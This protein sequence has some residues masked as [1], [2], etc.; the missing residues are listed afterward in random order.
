MILAMLICCAVQGRAEYASFTPLGFLP[1]GSNSQ[2]NAVSADGLVV[3]GEAHLP[4]GQSLQTRAFRWS[5]AEGM[6]ALGTLPGGGANWATAASLDGSVVVGAGVDSSLKSQAFRWTSA[7]GMVGLGFLSG[8]ANSY[9]A[10]VSATGTVVVGYGNY[11]Y[12]I[13][14]QAFRWTSGG[15]MTSLPFLTNSSYYAKASGISANGSVVVGEDRSSSASQRAVRWVNGSVAGL[16][17]PPGQNHS[18]ATAVSSDGSVVVGY[19]YN[20]VAG[21]FYPHQAFRW[22]MSSGIAS[23]GF[24][25]GASESDAYAVSA[26]GSAIV[27]TSGGRAFI[28]DPVRGMRDLQKNLIINHGAGLSG[29]T[30]NFASGISSSGTTIVGYG[31]DPNGNGQAWKVTLLPD[32]PNF[33]AVCV[34]GTNLIINGSSNFT[35]GTYYVWS[36][37]DLTAA[38]NAWFLVSTNHFD[39]NGNFA[40]TNAPSPASIQ[41]FYGLQ[42][43]LP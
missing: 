10:S 42:V 25:P 27:G 28:Y 31:T 8:Y 33:N 16:G 23:L 14:N 20:V 38:S 18:V 24:L 41:Q 6:V 36:S 19:G 35:N 32:P 13:A 5:D 43:P 26:D 4:V 15:G 30:L 2:A 7:T 1:G 22:A 34:D 40:F 3:V 21:E 37:I 29:W 12:L 11:N 39:A 9:A 17:F